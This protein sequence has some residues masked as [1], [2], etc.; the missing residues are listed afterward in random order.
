MSM[1][2][3]EKQKRYEEAAVEQA[4]AQVEADLAGRAKARAEK[5][6]ENAGREVTRWRV[7]VEEEN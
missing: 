5:R 3:E 7:A 6:L 2:K 1:S 4:R